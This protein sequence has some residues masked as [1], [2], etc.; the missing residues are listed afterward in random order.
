M[1]YDVPMIQSSGYVA[2]IDYSRRLRCGTCV[3]CCQFEATKWDDAPGVVWEKCMGRRVC[4]D[5]CAHYAISLKADEAKGLP[6]DFDKLC[7]T[8]VTSPEK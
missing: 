8:G 4:V 1:K 5:K 6:L 3:K 2:V 7:A